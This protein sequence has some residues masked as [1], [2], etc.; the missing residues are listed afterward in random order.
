MII[1]YALSISVNINTN[2]QFTSIKYCHVQLVE[3][4]KK[5]M[6]LHKK[7]MTLEVSITII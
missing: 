2:F 3:L 7:T 1:Y 4:K 6:F 5:L